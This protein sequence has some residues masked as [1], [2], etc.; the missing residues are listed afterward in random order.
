[1]AQRSPIFWATTSRQKQHAN[2]PPRPVLAAPPLLY[3]K[4][5]LGLRENVFAGPTTEEEN[6]STMASARFSPID[7][8]S[9]CGT[10]LTSVRTTELFCFVRSGLQP[11]RSLDRL[12]F[13]EFFA[14]PVLSVSRGRLPWPF[15][16]LLN[17][18]TYTL[19]S[20]LARGTLL[21]RRFVGDWVPSPVSRRFGN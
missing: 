19:G 17:A 16:R 18:S 7:E 9:L 12:F 14:N 6:S 2:S 21:L 20:S 1:M 15:G 8:R 13:P 3:T 10:S 4:R 5:N 11:L